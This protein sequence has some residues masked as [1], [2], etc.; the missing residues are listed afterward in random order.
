VIQQYPPKSWNEYRQVSLGDFYKLNA[1]E[2]CLYKYLEV[3]EQRGLFGELNSENPCEI[4]RN[5]RESRKLADNE[6]YFA[7]KKKF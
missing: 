1:R 6:K 5:A 3:M 2:D 4:L 7:L